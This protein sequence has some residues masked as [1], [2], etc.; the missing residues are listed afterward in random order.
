MV[1]DLGLN[2][3]REG[4]GEPPGG[5]YTF[6]AATNRKRRGERQNQARKGV[7]ESP[8]PHP[9]GAPHPGPP[10]EVGFVS[11]VGGAGA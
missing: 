4:L 2:Q 7:G 8:S 11:P 6:Q 10:P 1:E 9:Q 5:R 3:A